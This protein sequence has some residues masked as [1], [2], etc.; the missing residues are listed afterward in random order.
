MNRFSL[1]TALIILNLFVGCIVYF[2]GIFSAK[3]SA[4][5]AL[6]TIGLIAFIILKRDSHR[7]TYSSALLLYTVATQFGLVIP[8]LLIG[9]EVAG[10]YTYYTLRIS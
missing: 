9:R 10:N 6:I 1:N 7:L 5:Y 3:S 2:T 8:Y 4:V